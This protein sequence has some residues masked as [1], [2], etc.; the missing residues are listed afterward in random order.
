MKK[1]NTAE[2]QYVFDVAYGKE[3]WKVVAES[4]NTMARWDNGKV[5]AK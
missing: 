5:A 3:L 2:R 1:L 4:A